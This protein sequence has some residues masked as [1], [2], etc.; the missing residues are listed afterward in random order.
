M[1]NAIAED[2]AATHQPTKKLKCV[3]A[4]I[5]LRRETRSD[6]AVQETVNVLAANAIKP[7]KD[8]L[9]VAAIIAKIPMEQCRPPKE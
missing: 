8:I 4:A 3:N 5:L 7:N 6:E 9:T 1:S 2:F